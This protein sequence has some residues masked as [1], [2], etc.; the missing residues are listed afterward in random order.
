MTDTRTNRT[1]RKE[2]ALLDALR[3]GDSISA[4][5][6]AA[7]I[8]RSTYYEWRNT[9]PDFAAAADDAIE[10]GTDALEDEGKRRAMNGSDTML[11][12]LLKGRRREKYGDRQ[13]HELTGKDGEA[14]TILLT[15]RSDGPQ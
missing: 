6:R 1:A 10:E 11:I 8:A 2:K 14:L 15:P 7:G 9:H 12:F 5:V 3:D 4:A 13:S